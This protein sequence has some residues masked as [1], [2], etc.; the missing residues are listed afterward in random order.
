MSLQALAT[1]AVIG[2]TVLS[3]VGILS[4]GKAESDTARAESKFALAQA[5]QEAVRTA[6]EERLQRQRARKLIGTQKAQFAAS[7]VD[8]SSG[9][10]L[11]VMADTLLQSEEDVAAIRAG[12]AARIQTFERKA[13]TFREIGK[14]ARTGAGF[15]AGST[16]LTGLGGLT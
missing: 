6:E 12:G 7:G 1:G 2:G 13:Q 3:S 11:L 15:K 4:A 9:T 8:I 16:L 14:A 5:Q 10:P